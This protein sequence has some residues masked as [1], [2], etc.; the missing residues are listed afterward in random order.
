MWIA[1]F[2]SRLSGRY[3]KRAYLEVKLGG[4]S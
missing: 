3:A 1:D 4:T 2:F